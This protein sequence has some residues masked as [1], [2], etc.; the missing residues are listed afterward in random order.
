MKESNKIKWSKLI[1]LH[2]NSGLSIVDFCKQHNISTSTFYKYRLALRK[3]KNNQPSTSQFIQATLSAEPHTLIED[4]QFKI[5]CNNIHFLLSRSVD[6]TWFANVLK[7][8]T[9]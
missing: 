7:G 8:L 3:S 4:N 5:T 1:E 9:S 2:P 6:P